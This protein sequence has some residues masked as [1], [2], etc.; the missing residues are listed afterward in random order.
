MPDHD[1]KQSTRLRDPIGRAFQ[2]LRYMIEQPQKNFGVREVAKACD[3]QPGTVHRALNALLDEG[4]VEQNKDTEEYRVGIDMVRLGVRA[5]EKIEMR[6]VARPILENVAAAFNETVLLGLYNPR[7]RLM[8]RVD[9]VETGHPL[10]Y[11]FELYQWTD[12]YRGAS[13]LAILANLPAHEQDTILRQAEHDPS[14]A[15]EGRV[16]ATAELSAIKEQ[17]YALTHGRRI[18]GAVGVAAPIFDYRNTVIGDLIVTVP[19][20]RFDDNVRQELIERLPAAAAEISRNLGFVQAE[21]EMSG[22][23]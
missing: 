3:M 21:P 7:T 20:Q 22:V 18:Q 6:Q 12:I 10:R 8:S 11:F 19:E 16:S 9:S 4:F 17:G 1:K 13:G 23:V 5:A 2:V 15:W 14:V